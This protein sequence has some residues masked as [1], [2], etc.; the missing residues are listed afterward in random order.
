MTTFE[1][2]LVAA[3]FAG[4]RSRSCVCGGMRYLRNADQSVKT[5]PRVSDAAQQALELARALAE[6]AAIAA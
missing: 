1:S 5:S 2:L 4:G 6:Q 3:M